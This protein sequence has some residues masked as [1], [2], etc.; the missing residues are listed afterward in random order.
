MRP[1]VFLPEFLI[2]VHPPDPHPHPQGR[3]SERQ[4]L[5]E[6]PGE[7]DTRPT[8]KSRLKLGYPFSLVLGDRT[9]LRA[10][11]HTGL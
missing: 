10:R 2:G 11:L 4:R 6:I 1:L 5:A 3:T 7:K 8:F 9:V